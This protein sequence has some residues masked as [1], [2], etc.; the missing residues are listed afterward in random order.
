MTTLAISQVKSMETGHVQIVE[1]EAIVGQ[2]KLTQKYLE[3]TSKA[4]KEEIH[5]LKKK[6]K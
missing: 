6:Q 1:K 4:T 5:L 2:L 3:Q